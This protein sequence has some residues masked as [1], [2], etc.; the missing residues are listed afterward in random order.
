[1][2]GKATHDWT[3]LKATKE[4]LIAVVVKSVATSRDVMFAVRCLNARL[5][6]F[7]TSWFD[8]SMT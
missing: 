7:D 3:R 5:L 4:L 6:N 8:R 1:M 2:T